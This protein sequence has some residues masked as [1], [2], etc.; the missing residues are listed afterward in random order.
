MSDPVLG[1]P[2]RELPAI[3]LAAVLVAGV[4]SDIEKCTG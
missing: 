1:D 4:E 3:D 2:A